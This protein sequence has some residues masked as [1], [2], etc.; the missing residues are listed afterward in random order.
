MNRDDARRVSEAVKAASAPALADL[1]YGVELGPAR[2]G[3]TYVKLTLQIVALPPA[4]A[5]FNPNTPEAQDFVAYAALEGIDPAALGRP[6][7]HN[8]QTSI[9]VGLR[10]RASRFPILCRQADGREIALT[11]SHVARQHPRPTP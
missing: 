4:G 6:V 10:R 9:I 3:D 5:E 8:N 2:Y 1:G 11:A 7:T